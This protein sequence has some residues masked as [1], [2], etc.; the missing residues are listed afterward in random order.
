MM[1]NYGIIVMA[2]L[3]L[4]MGPSGERAQHYYKIVDR[5][6]IDGSVLLVR[7]V[8]S[9]RVGTAPFSAGGPGE[10][11][12]VT[13]FFRVRERGIPAGYPSLVGDLPAVTCEGGKIIPGDWE[14]I[15]KGRPSTFFEPGEVVRLVSVSSSSRTVRMD[16]EAVCRSEAVGK[17]LRGR[18]D[19]VLSDE[20]GEI[21]LDKANAAVR[22][23]LEPI[24]LS[25]V[26]EQCDPK[27]GK[28]P[29]TLRKGMKVHEVEV[30]FGGKPAETVEEADGVVLDY[31]VVRLVTRGD[32]VTDILIPIPQ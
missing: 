19:F 15:F 7:A 28:P 30:I 32:T 25:R 16:I 10:L 9:H 2:L 24:G 17:R 14:K 11:V 6:D 13:E 1:K 26:F 3:V 12:P 5:R 29:I 23:V 31:G 4:G 27:T 8:H 20:V 21:V 22:K 18:I